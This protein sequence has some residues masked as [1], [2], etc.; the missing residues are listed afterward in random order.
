MSQMCRAL[1]LVSQSGEPTGVAGGKEEILFW[2][3]LSEG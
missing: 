3:E 1:I 2:K